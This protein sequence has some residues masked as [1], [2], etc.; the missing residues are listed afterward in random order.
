MFALRAAS[1]LPTA[2]ALIEVADVAAL[3]TGAAA[4]AV[5]AAAHAAIHGMDS[6]VRVLCV[7]N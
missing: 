2:T 3:A 5:K 4:A 7:R 1:A 6:S